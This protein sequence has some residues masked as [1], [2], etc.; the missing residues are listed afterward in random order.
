[1]LGWLIFACIIEKKKTEDRLALLKVI[2]MKFL[3]L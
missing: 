3:V 2:L 1:M